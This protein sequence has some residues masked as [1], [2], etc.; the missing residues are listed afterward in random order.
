M[1]NHWY[2][3]RTTPSQTRAHGIVGYYVVLRE[4]RTATN[5][6][7]EKFNKFLGFIHISNDLF[8]TRKEAL[9]FG[10]EEARQREVFGPAWVAQQVDA[11]ECGIGRKS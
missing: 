5:R 9:D 3:V 7:G 6:F 8:P 4:Y 10:R 2:S 1:K 11:S